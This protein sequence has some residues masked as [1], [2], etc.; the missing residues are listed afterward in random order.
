LHPGSK[1]FLR[2]SARRSAL[3]NT[4]PGNIFNSIKVV[5]LQGATPNVP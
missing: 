4:I 5:N 3:M 2:E 1:F